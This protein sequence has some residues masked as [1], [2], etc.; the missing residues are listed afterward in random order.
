LCSVIGQLLLKKDWVYYLK[1]RLILMILSLLIVVASAES[2]SLVREKRALSP[3]DELK[4]EDCLD[5][6]GF[7]IKKDGICA[8]ASE[9]SVKR[10]MI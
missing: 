2:E 7:P 5:D 3:D 1:M 9:L 6:E 8:M 10:N 4:L